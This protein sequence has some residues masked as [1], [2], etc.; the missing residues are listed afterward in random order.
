MLAKIVSALKFKN[1]FF[2]LFAVKSQKKKNSKTTD[3]ETIFIGRNIFATRFGA[4]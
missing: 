1:F 3:V 4:N 2:S